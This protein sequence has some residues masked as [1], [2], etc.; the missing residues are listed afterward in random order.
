MRITLIQ[1]I[2]IGFSIVTLSAIALSL[3]A[4]YS[5]KKMAK[6]LEL[7]A[8]TL[9]QLLDQTNG[10]GIFLEDANR[11]TLI[12]A[13]TTDPK[14]REYFAKGI[15]NA[16]N[17]YSERYK[18]LSEEL[19]PALGVTESLNHLNTAAQKTNAE[20]MRHIDIH[21]QR[22]QARDAAYSEL[23]AGIILTRTL[24]I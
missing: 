4:G 3:S 13:N 9:T 7:S 20:L 11:L 23:Y 12:H 2:V 16:L 1:R 10:L 22:L 5:Q 18:E 6:Q 21:N 14:K 24:L 15:K 8:S 19:D 17:D